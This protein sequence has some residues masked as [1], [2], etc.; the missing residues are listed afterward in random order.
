MVE[1]PHRNKGGGSRSSGVM[2]P[3]LWDFGEYESF[4]GGCWKWLMPR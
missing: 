3:A 4:G 1:K 2:V